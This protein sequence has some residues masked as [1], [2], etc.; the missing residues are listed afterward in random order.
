LVAP[1][2]AAE[3]RFAV[4]VAAGFTLLTAARLLAHELWRDEAW[5]WLVVGESRSLGEL[6]AALSRSGQG[7][8]FPLLCFLA[9]QLWTSWRAMQLLNLAIAGAAAFV[10][11]RWAPFGR[12]ERL[13]FVLGYL[14]FYEY[15]VL[16]RH[17]ATGMLLLWLA[18][19][20]ARGRRPALA[21]GA[22]LG[23][24]CQT[25]VY[26]FILAVAVGIGWLLERWIH[27]REW[28]P[29]SRGEAAAG[30]A[31]AATG[32]V[33][34]LVQLA[35]RP[36]TS[37]A[38]GWNLSWQPDVAAR[39]AQMPWRAI[40]PLPRLE[41]HFWNTNI[42]ETWPAALTVLGGVALAA[43]L[44][45]LWPRKVAVA[46]FAVGAFGLLAF[47]Y[48]KYLGTMRHQGHLWLLLVAALWLA[49]GLPGDL[50]PGPA[51][52]PTGRAAHS[53]RARLLLSFLVV[54]CGAAAWASWVDL[55]N[56]FSN[57]ARTAE[58]L[59]RS[60]LERYPLLGYREPPAA[61]VA[62][63]LGKPLFAPSRG[64]FTTHP[65][66]GPEQHDL[67]A[68]ELRCVAR[69]L[70]QREGGDII[71]VMNQELPAWGELQPAGARV[72]AV[73]ATEDYH[74]YRLLRD[75]LPPTAVEAACAGSS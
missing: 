11:A 17:Y 46:T 4:W 42:L 49:G 41:L 21:L 47:G 63:A 55:R 28:S 62:L 40:A 32:L 9:R 72:G 5:L 39:V 24:L 25:T 73:V 57:A 1:E 66:W 68:A 23:L 22:A 26:G 33:A 14:P 15:A 52:Q 69:G 45:L 43:A 53:W 70:A 54:H 61:S 12:R 16:S 6:W 18:C 67:P 75:R 59:R 19:A 71:L 7:Y 27:R 30:L 50:S 36:G 37:F 38:P 58:L 8:L 51:S 44:A 13:L 34:G 65:D 3:R 64:I 10:F 20:G 2:P 31:L 35:P 48:V 29:L 56:P 60:G 74:L